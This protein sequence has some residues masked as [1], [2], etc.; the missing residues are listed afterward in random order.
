M[1][2]QTP[3]DVVDLDFNPELFNDVYFH[4]DRDFNDPL[5]RFIF[6]YGGSSASKTFTVVQKIITAMLS[7]PDENHLVLRKFGTDI[8]DSIYADFK[9]IIENWGLGEYFVI[10]QNFILCSTGSFVR[11]RG[12]D[13]SEKVKG[14]SQFKRIVL[15]E[16]SQFEEVDLK[17]IRKRLRGRANQQIIGIF[18]PISENHWIKKKLFDTI[19][20]IDVELEDNITGKWLSD[21]GNFVL[22]KLTYLNNK[23]IIGPNFVD[24]HTIDDFE[25]DRVNDNAYY[26]IYALGNWGILKTGG[27]FYKKFDSNKHVGRP[28][29][30]AEMPLHISFDFNVNP[31]MTCTIWQLSNKF[32]YQVDEICLKSP[33]NTTKSVCKEF[34][35]KYMS[36]AAG[37]FVYGDPNGK[38][39]DTRSE[40]GH[41]DFKIIMDDLAKYHPSKRV[42][43]KAPFVV[44]RGNFINTILQ[45]N[46]EGIHILI[47]ENCQHTIDDY[48]YLKEASDGTKHKEKA[49]DPSTQIVYEKWGH[50]SD[51]NDYFLCRVFADEYALYQN[52]GPALPPMMGG[53]R[54]TK[55]F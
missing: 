27:E 5:I 8:K 23:Y 14:I 55:R 52:G 17:Q 28:L 36:H 34:T 18:N 35:R 19:G 1:V 44:M 13:D 22:Y 10:Q 6:L 40:Q 16:I 7:G 45:Q 46:F 31:Y 39:E 4:L 32:A 38:R 20:W 29:Y 11:F 12:L 21:K 15:E 2:S 47:N 50:T 41:N 26:Q 48:S 3:N 25:N 51:A 24:Q 53:T 49:K 54:G 33:N 9:A 42:D 43:E 30:D 37:L